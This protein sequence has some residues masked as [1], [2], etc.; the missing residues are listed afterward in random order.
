MI[1]QDK[2]FT[3]IFNHLIQDLKAITNGRYQQALGQSEQDLVGGHISI[4]YSIRQLTDDIPRE[5]QL[6]LRGNRR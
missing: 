3:N 6:F 4:Q 2:S 1:Q 5:R